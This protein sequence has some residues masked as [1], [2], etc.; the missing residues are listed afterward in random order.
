MRTSSWLFIFEVLMVVAVGATVANVAIEMYLGW[1]PV[2]TSLVGQVLAAAGATM[3]ALWL[4]RRS[5][6]R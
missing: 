4:K 5:G 6:P 3:F 1:S 2:S